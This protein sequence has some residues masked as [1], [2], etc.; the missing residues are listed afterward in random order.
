M[1]FQKL[2]IFCGIHERFKPDQVLQFTQSSLATLTAAGCVKSPLRRGWLIETYLFV[3]SQDAFGSPSLPRGIRASDS[4]ALSPQINLLRVTNAPAETGGTADVSKYPQSTPAPA[5]TCACRSPR[6]RHSAI[7]S[8]VQS[9]MPRYN[10]LVCR[11][12]LTRLD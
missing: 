9:V 5:E 8:S 6:W 1:N 3:C 12:V 10:R 11:T 2:F 4:E 7:A